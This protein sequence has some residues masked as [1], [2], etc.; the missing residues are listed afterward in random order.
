[1]T[2]GFIICAGLSASAGIIG[3]LYFGGSLGVKLAVAAFLVFLLPMWVI[4]SERRG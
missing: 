4:I 3:Y 2:K 1:M